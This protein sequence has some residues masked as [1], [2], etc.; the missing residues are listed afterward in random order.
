MEQRYKSTYSRNS[1]DPHKKDLLVCSIGAVASLWLFFSCL[2][3]HSREGPRTLLLVISSSRNRI[4]FSLRFFPQT[5]SRQDMD[6]GL[7]GFIKDLNIDKV[8]NLAEDA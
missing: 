2:L 4:H 7:G 5:N 3:G 8:R 1:Y 6:L